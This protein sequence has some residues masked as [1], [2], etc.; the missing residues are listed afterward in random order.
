CRLVEGNYPNYNSVIPRNNPRKLIVDRA[1]FY[2]TLKR[3]SVFSN[4]ASN[5]VRLHLTGNQ[6]TVSAQDIDFSISAYER[7]A[8]QYEGDEMEIGFKAAFLLEILANLSS[9][10]VIVE[11]ADPTRAGLFLPSETENESEDL[12]ML[13]MPMMINA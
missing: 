11:L 1:G 10:E 3:V 7:I 12:L 13:L 2:N 5:L 6:V 4:Q 9:P 8:C